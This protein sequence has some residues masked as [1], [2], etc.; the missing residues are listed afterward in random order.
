MKVFLT[1][2][3]AVSAVSALSVG[4]TI[5]P[6]AKIVEAP[7]SYD[8]MWSGSEQQKDNWGNKVESQRRRVTIRSSENDTDDVSSDFLWGINTAS[9]GGLLHLEK[10][11]TYVIGTKL[12]LPL[13]DDVYVKLDGEIKVRYLYPLLLKSTRML[14]H[15]PSIVYGRYRVLANKQ[16]LL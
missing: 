12:D 13:L 7:A 14:K 8:H 6:G 9:H 5:P 4:S 15:Y 1:V 2:L 3:L 10:G 11:K 16:L